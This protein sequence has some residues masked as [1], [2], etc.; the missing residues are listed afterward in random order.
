MP[1]DISLIY[2]LACL[3]PSLIV[4]HGLDTMV[5]STSEI[6]EAGSHERLYWKSFCSVFNTVVL[7]KKVITLQIVMPRDSFFC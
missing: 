6:P 5:I 2:F 1:T 4:A 3:V 7:N